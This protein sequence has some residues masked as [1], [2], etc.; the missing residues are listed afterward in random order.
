MSYI[1][2]SIEL[3]RDKMSKGEAFAWMRDHGYPIHKMEM[4]RNFY[5]FRQVEPERLRGGRFRTIA[6]GDVG[7]LIVV[8]F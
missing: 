6:L 8:Y 3:R 4:S 2:Q 1:V 5:H 7:H